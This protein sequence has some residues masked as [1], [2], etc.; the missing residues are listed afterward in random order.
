MERET[1]LERTGGAPAPEAERMRS[2]RPLRFHLVVAVL[3]SLLPLLVFTGAIVR[4]NVDLQDD[5]LRQG[6]VYASSALSLAVDRE[7]GSI[8]AIL[9]TL[10]AS[11]ELDI[12]DLEGFHRLCVKAA[13]RRPGSRILLFDAAG[14]PLSDSASSIGATGLLGP[15]PPA[16]LEE[17][18]NTPHAPGNSILAGLHA[19][20]QVFETGQPVYSH[21]FFAP[22]SGLPEISLDVPV[23]RDGRVVYSLRMT[24]SPQGFANLL[25]EEETPHGAFAGVVDRRG[26]M[27]ARSADH[28]R[29]VGVSANADLR[30]AL[31]RGERWGR[32]TSLEGAPV[33]F[34]WDRSPLTGWVTFVAMHEGARYGQGHRSI[35][36]WAGG[37][38]CLLALGVVLAARVARRVTTPL[39]TLARS[40]HLVQEGSPV[41]VPRQAVRE[42]KALYEALAVAAEAMRRHAAERERRLAAEIGREQ[43]EEENRRKDEFVAMLSHELRNPL[44][45]I[46]NAASFLNLIE[47]DER[48]AHAREIIVRQTHHL[49]RLL[50]DVLDL[51]RT[52]SGKVVLDVQPI[53]LGAVAERAADT[54]R[55]TGKATGYE[56]VVRAEPVVVAGDRVRLE[57]VA[58][59]LLTNA[60]RHT[61]AGS[62]IEIET[63]VEGGDAVLRVRDNGGGIAPQT[64][65]RVFDLFFQVQSSLDRVNRGLGIGLTLVKRLVELHQGTVEAASEGLGKGSEFTVRLPLS[66][67]PVATAE[68][69]PHEPVGRGLSIAIVEDNADIRDMLRLLLEAEGHRVQVAGEGPA[70]LALIQERRP[71]VA[72]VD[73][74]LPGLDGYQVARAVRES[75]EGGQVRLVA[76]T[77]YGRQEDRARG[78]EAG[79]DVYLVKPIDGKKLLE[80]LDDVRSGQAHAAG[81]RG[82]TGNTSGRGGSPAGGSSTNDSRTNGSNDPR[83][84]GSTT[85]V[86]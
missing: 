1:P 39:E 5:S 45:A 65:P 49:S 64:L 24:S 30:G 66:T 71:D 25:Q 74:G 81:G 61:P 76:M 73:I 83:T 35:L 48:G 3:A 40:A 2:G 18:T 50:E 29:F 85:F 55:E 17:G 42:V 9:N 7:W 79:F 27:V 31:G 14:R 26:V 34:A 82:P 46:A 32:G 6:M 75:P 38:A 10:A 77:G 15:P 13:G 20:R 28:E 78:A 58:L 54:L 47:K 70:G 57:Q 11:R 51:S 23:V 84:N 80:L 67:Q 59:N 41:A 21:L 16:V 33:Y 62:R 43:A 12:G 68:Q 52:I 53:D 22:E 60:L 8:R 44:A 37:A 86:A 72:L 4:H 63:L 56:L 36:L 69:R 19:L